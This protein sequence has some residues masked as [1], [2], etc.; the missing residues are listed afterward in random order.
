MSYVQSGHSLSTG[1]GH[2]PDMSL[3]LS[4]SQSSG[5]MHQS[6]VKYHWRTIEYTRTFILRI[7]NARSFFQLERQFNISGLIISF[8]LARQGAYLTQYIWMKSV[9]N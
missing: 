4:I 5:A 3:Y 1:T 6:L 2:K 9:R 7:R 8:T